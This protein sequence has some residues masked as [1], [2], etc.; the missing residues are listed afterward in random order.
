MGT[1]CRSRHHNTFPAAF[2]T[3]SITSTEDEKAELEVAFQ[4]FFATIKVIVYA[5]D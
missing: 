4:F 1:A 2:R 5:Y 3:Q